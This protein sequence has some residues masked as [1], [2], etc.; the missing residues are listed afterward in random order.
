M[1][2]M[3]SLPP[4][5]EAHAERL[6][7]EYRRI[8]LDLSPTSL[9]DV[10]CGAGGLLASLAARGVEARGIEED[11]ARCATLRARGVDVEQGSAHALD[12]PNDS[13]DWVS[14]RH[15]LHHLPRPTSAVREAWRVARF[16]IVMAEPHLDPTLERH[17]RMAELED[18]L[19]ALD[20][21]SGRVHGPNMTADEML[22]LIDDVPVGIEQWTHVPLTN[23][24]P[25][26]YDFLVE[27][28]RAGAE[29]DADQSRVLRR[30]RT[31]AERRGISLPGSR[32][33][34]VRKRPVPPSP[35]AFPETAVAPLEVA[36]GLDRPWSP[37]LVAALNGQKVQV[38][39]F[40]GPFDLH[41]HPG[42]DEA[43]FVLEGRV[44]IEFDDG[45]E[46]VAL[47]A[48]D[49]VVVPRG[50]PHRPV[51]DGTAHVLMFEP[52]GTRNTG[53]QVS[54]RTR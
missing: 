4:A 44:R 10:G 46:A 48:G 17:A 21:A 35:R 34:C 5:L 11:E 16:G 50:T 1:G 49:L 42:E 47:D 15:V 9:L 7:A 27:R 28:S 53:D 13:Y 33:L 43:F 51:A 2:A 40:E 32:I 22:L 14:L 20:R 38:A 45:R 30:L 23:V 37:E 54:E 3:P 19:R 25:G 6:R 18:V 39:R 29:P 26:D 36:R 52:L 8:V 31:V 24:A 41:A 12:A